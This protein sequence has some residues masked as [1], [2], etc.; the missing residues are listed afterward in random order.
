MPRPI[1]LNQIFSN[2]TANQLTKLIMSAAQGR[3]VIFLRTVANRAESG[4]AGLSTGIGSCGI[5]A[6][7][8]APLSYKQ[9]A[10]IMYIN[11]GTHKSYRTGDSKC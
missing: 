3:D 10:F 8:T 1:F 9:R 4:S 11:Y 5:G 7:S 6:L 2:L